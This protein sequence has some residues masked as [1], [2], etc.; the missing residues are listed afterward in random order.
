MHHVLLAAGIARHQH[1]YVL[2]EI[3]TPPVTLAVAGDALLWKCS[4]RCSPI[5]NPGAGS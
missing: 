1:R 4:H 3:M 2:E 5:L